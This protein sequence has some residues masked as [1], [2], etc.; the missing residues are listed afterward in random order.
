MNAFWLVFV[1]LL[2]IANTTVVLLSVL[3]EGKYIEYFYNL[4]KIY[5]NDTSMKSREAIWNNTYQ[6]IGQT[7]PMSLII[8]RGFGTMNQMVLAMN[9]F[10]KYLFPTHNGYLNL[11]AEGGFPYLLSYLLLLGYVIYY[12]VKNYRTN[13]RAAVA[14]TI[15]LASFAIY[16][17]NETIHYFTYPFMFLIFVYDNAKVKPNF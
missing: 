13:P 4:Y 17:L 16:S 8:G 1:T 12:V 11:L 9:G 5:A 7:L 14:L 2:L 3:S 6:I 10:K 15:G